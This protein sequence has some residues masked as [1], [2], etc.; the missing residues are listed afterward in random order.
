MLESQE[1]KNQYTW[2][3][4]VKHYPST[5]FLFPV[6]VNELK[7]PVL[8]FK[9]LPEVSSCKMFSTFLHVSNSLHL[10][11]FLHFSIPNFD[12]IYTTH[13]IVLFWA[14]NTPALKFEFEH[15]AYRPHD[16]RK[17]NVGTPTLQHTKFWHNL[18]YTLDC[19]VLGIKYT[20]FQIW[21][22]TWS[23]MIWKKKKKLELLHSSIPKFDTT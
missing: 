16:L 17:K 8:S 7:N 12:T 1:G 6:Y 19:I 18:N 3:F 15:E 5:L 13:L 4:I 2:M 14:L 21:I 10:Y 20:S 22:W 23:F 11:A 9:L